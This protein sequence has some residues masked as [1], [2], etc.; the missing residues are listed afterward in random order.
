MSHSNY[1]DD[2]LLIEKAEEEASNERLI[3]AGRLLK[4]V[5]DDSLLEKKHL[6]MIR[7]ADEIEK[8]INNILVSPDEDGNEWKKQGETHGDRD[9]LVYYKVNEHNQLSCRIDCAIESS[10]L[11]PLLSVFNESDLFKTWM[12]SYK[13]PVKLG[14]RGSKMLKESGRGNQTIL[15]TVDMAWPM[16]TREV[17][18]H[19]VSVDVIEEKASIA[20]LAKSETSEDDPIIPEPLPSHVRIDFEQTILIRGCPEDHPCLVKSRNKYPENE[21][22]IMISIAMTVD[23]HVKFVPLT[24]INFVTRTVIGRMWSSTLKVAEDI[25]DGK[26]VMHQEAISKKKHLYGWIEERIQLML[27]KLKER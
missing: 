9:F 27:D 17:V 10:L 26:R 21:E 14:I 4:E 16:C 12:P 2:K 1:E 13:R 7:W 5:K 18:L 19:A 24:L 3:E 20:I 23:A 25:R 8:S 15:V 11:V 6:T 22:L